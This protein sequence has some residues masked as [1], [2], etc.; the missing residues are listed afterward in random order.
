MVALWKKTSCR[1]FSAYGR[2]VLLAQ[3]VV[4]TSRNL[5][6]DSLIEMINS[7]RAELSKLQGNPVLSAEE[8]TRLFE[9]VA[10]MKKAFYQIADLCIPN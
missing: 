7:T 3:P 10:D 1:T 5:S 9:L 6:L 8:K 4:S 2:K